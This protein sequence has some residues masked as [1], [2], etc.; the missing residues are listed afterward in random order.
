ME[1]EPLPPIPSPFGSRWRFDYPRLVHVVV[2]LVACGLATLLWTRVQ[3]PGAFVGQVEVMQF[4]V[5]SRDAGYITNLF[6]RPL[7]PIQAGDPVAEI[8]TTD[9]RTVN[10]RLEAMRDRM[11]LT[12][13]ELDPILRRERSTLA[14]EQL[15]VDCERVRAELNVARVRLD[16]A[17]AQLGR[18]QRLFKERILSP[19]LFDLSMRN[20]NAFA[21]E[22]EAKSNLVYRTEKALERLKS[23]ADT[24]VPGGEN[25]PIRQALAVEEDKMRV[26]EA[27]AAPLRLSA[28]TNG[29]VTAVL[30]HAGEQVQAAEPVITI[31]T[32][33]ATRIVGYLPFGHLVEPVVGME[34]EVLSRGRIRRRGV[35]RLTGMTPHFQSITNSFVPPTVARPTVVPPFARVLS[36]T[37]PPEMGLV[38]GEPVDLT[39]RPRA[40]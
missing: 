25:D 18:D 14:Y 23:M 7:Q 33:N 30:R 19:E 9:P 8:V 39:L 29:I 36:I 17:E 6:V 4:T 20:K 10:N 38:P 27:K 2:F 16:Q 1:Q 37:L 24:F 40:E 11:R 34:V 28:P 13:L 35:A 32:T 5:A 26:F 12:A 3:G 22:V 31:T 21:V 15:S